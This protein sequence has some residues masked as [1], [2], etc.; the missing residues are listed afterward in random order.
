MS[1]P[2][3]IAL[4]NLFTPNVG[5]LFITTTT[6]MYM[7]YEFMHFC[8]HV[9]ENW[10]V[11]NMPIINTNRR[12][13]TAHHD[14]SIMMNYNMNLTFPIMDWLFGSSDLDRGLMG[15]LFNGYDTRYV[16][17][18]MHTTSRTPDTLASG[19]IRPAE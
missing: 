12:H 5:W 13:H 17:T 8:C 1:I 3:A 10:F 4:G 7:I 6:S 18:D 16:R 2:A 19:R 15:T 9:Q 14:P 11:R